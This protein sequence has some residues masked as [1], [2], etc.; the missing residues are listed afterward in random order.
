MGRTYINVSEVERSS[1]KGDAAV[2]E[3]T[4]AAEGLRTVTWRLDAEILRRN[5]IR[6]RLEEAYRQAAQTE[7]ELRALCR[8]VQQGAD[9]YEG[10]ERRVIY[11]SQSILGLCNRKAYTN[12]YKPYE[13]GAVAIATAA[14]SVLGKEVDE[15]SLAWYLLKYQT[16]NAEHYLGKEELEAKAEGLFETGIK[17]EWRENEEKKLN[18]KLEKNNLAWEKEDTDYYDKQDKEIEEK[19]APDFYERETT[20]AEVSAEASVSKS[21]YEG[22]YSTGGEGC[23]VKAV[24]GNAEAHT[25]ISGGFYVVEKDGSRK[26]SPGVKAEIGASVTALDVEWKQQWLGDENLGLNT[27]IGVTVGK[28]EAVAEGIVQVFNDE[29]KVDVQV[30]IGASAEL[31]GG[32]IE[33]SIGVN[34][35]GGEIGV[36]GGINYGIGAHADIG[37]RD[38]VFK[39]DVGAS[40]GVGASLDLE[41]DIGGMVDTIA[42]NAEAVWDGAKEAWGAFTSLF[43]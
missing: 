17:R 31:I 4:G 19:D 37:Y 33:G 28:A 27:D 41:V 3:V 13:K 36:S 6:Y 42:D 25:S 16:G 29:G 7:R 11:L 38:G 30:G 9:L 10:T 12:I 26:F 22:V 39:F 8:S 5:N 15:D 43:D 18:K 21:F 20:I 1:V 23:E 32:E 24:V 14:W 34:V 40:L 35:L 2:K